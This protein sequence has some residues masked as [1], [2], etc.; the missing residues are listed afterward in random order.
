MFNI[1]K[2]KTIFDMFTLHSDLD[3]VNEEGGRSTAWL[4]ALFCVVEF[5]VEPELRARTG[6]FMFRTGD[7][8]ERDNPGGWG[9]VKGS[10]TECNGWVTGT[11]ATGDVYS[12]SFWPSHCGWG[13]KT[14]KQGYNKEHNIRIGQFF[15]NVWFVFGCFYRTI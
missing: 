2:C 6:G 1:F 4:S 13:L 11:D 14:R 9:W 10:E 15:K 5:P 12:G 3:A 7:E 8:I